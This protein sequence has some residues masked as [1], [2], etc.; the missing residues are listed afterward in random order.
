MST[1]VG[2]LTGTMAISEKVD[3]VDVAHTSRVSSGRL[4]GHRATRR[5]RG[6]AS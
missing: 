1:K 2:A 5:W 4:D 3:P 6:E